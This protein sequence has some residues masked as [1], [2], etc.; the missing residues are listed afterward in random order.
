MLGTIL[1]T[2]ILKTA[3]DKTIKVWSE[4]NKDQAV[5]GVLLKE[6]VTEDMPKE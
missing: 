4:S 5:D 6:I 1:V 3:L 2:V